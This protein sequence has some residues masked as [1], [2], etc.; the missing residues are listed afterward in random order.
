[1]LSDLNVGRQTRVCPLVS[2]KPPRPP[3]VIS[4][5]YMHPLDFL[6]LWI[7]TWMKYIPSRHLPV[8]NIEFDFIFVVFSWL[9]AALNPGIKRACSPF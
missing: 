6:R 1:M 4:Y 8:F 5:L 2:L 3:F 9:I 7:R